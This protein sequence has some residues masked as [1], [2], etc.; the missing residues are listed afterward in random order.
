MASLTSY[1]P[2]TPGLLPKW[3]LLLS[4]VS[5][6]NS[7]QAY[8]SL[9]PTRRVYSG[10]SS[11]SSRTPSSSSSPVNPLSARTFG[12]WT[13]LASIIRLYAAYHITNP[14]VYE[15]AFWTYAV[16]WA[17][18]FSEWWVFG[19]ARW[20]PGLMGP[21]V[22]SSVSLVWMWVQWGVYHGA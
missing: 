18:F 7:I 15:L 8:T 10:T 12:T 14:Q 22:I 16:A 20:G 21:V 13:L 19:T 11:P 3:F 17:H 2:Q 6:G 1:L 5:I 9:G 4:I